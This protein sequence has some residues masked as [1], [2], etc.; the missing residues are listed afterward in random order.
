MVHIDDQLY[1]LV[2]MVPS[3]DASLDPIE[4]DQQLP[5]GIP[6]LQSKRAMDD[7][8]TSSREVEDIMEESSTVRIVFNRHQN[9]HM[10][11]NSRK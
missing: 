4:D 1:S 6:P 3:N 8:Y 9:G 7:P 10:I 11:D 5:E 2:L